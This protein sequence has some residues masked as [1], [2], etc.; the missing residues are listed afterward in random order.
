MQSRLLARDEYCNFSRKQWRCSLPA[1]RRYRLD[2]CQHT[3][4]P[5]SALTEAAAGKVKCVREYGAQYQV[6]C[7]ACLST[8]HSTQGKLS[9]FFKNYD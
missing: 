4:A 7:N 5:H 1:R 6:K 9:V 3:A 2:R 8:A